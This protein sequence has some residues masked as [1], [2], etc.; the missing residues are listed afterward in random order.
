MKLRMYIGAALLAFAAVP[1]LA[2]AQGRPQRA[3]EPQP[4]TV[5]M[6][7]AAVEA[8]EAAAIEN[9]WNVIIVVTD[10]AGIP[11]YV[12][13]RDNTMPQAWN[14]VMGKVRTVLGSGL[15]TKEYAEGVAAGTVTAVENA[16]ALD[17]GFPI[18]M[19]GEV[20]GAIAASGV[21]P[22]Q[23]ATVARAGL[24]TIPGN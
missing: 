4:L 18:K 9:N 14:F 7:E 20:V 12:K 2:E 17:G 16:V 3:Q 10:A 5:A 19:N 24:V 1:S 15:S 8:A 23:D 6:A 11:I 21:R 13:R 22:D